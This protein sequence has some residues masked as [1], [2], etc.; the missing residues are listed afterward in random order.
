MSP[1]SLCIR[2]TKLHGHKDRI[3]VTSL[4]PSIDFAETRCSSHE[5]PRPL[6]PS[7]LH[8]V[9][10]TVCL[11]SQLHCFCYRSSVSSKGHF[12]PMGHRRFNTETETPIAVWLIWYKR[13]S[14][15]TFCTI[16]TVRPESLTRLLCGFETAGL[17]REVSADQF[18]CTIQFNKVRVQFRLD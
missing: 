4:R 2:E 3:R 8:E 11:P 13:A 1:T 18:S 12:G 17:Y 16:H 5:Q 14:L 9:G 7:R 15:T 10:W 6:I